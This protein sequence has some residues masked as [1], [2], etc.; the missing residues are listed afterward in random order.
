MNKKDASVSY[1]FEKLYEPSKQHFNLEKK[2]DKNIK[3]LSEIID[4]I[5]N[6]EK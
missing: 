5:E 6:V 2:R 3:K 4:E 1:S